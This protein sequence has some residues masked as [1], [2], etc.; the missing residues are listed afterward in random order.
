MPHH[1]VIAQHHTL[2]H[3]PAQIVTYPQYWAHR[4][5][6]V[7]AC[8][9]TSLGCHTDLWD[10]HKGEFS[11]LLDEMRLR[12]CLTPPRK[13]AEI[14][15]PILP[16]IASRTG[17]PPNTPV[18]CGIHDSNASLLPHLVAQ[19][20]PFSVVSTGTWVVVMTVGGAPVALDGSRDTLI[21]I[22]AFG[23]PTPSARFMGGREYDR[24]RGQGAAPGAHD[25]RD[26]LDNHLFLLPSVESATG[27]FQGRTHGWAPAEPD[28][29]DPR[30]DVALALYLAL[31]TAECLAITGANG[32]V[33][34]EGPFAQNPLYL[35]ML[36]AATGF[37]VT[38]SAS[39]T[40]T[41]VGAALLFASPVSVQPAWPPAQS[42][43]D[44]LKMI[45]YAKAWRAAVDR[46]V[47]PAAKP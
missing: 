29:T 45:G 38:A 6:G 8:D 27:P 41:A 17:L 15:G 7:A 39:Q 3:R 34:V 18:A 23:Q 37:P 25:V 22:N 5:T 36:A 31:M 2:R 9:I 46:R 13:P 16:K 14:L 12:V 28:V 35:A 44:D 19:T 21:N 33:I 26:V 10:P 20:P 11:T 4:L 42:A 40:G 24:M 47:N 32:P 43:P 30:R 1:V